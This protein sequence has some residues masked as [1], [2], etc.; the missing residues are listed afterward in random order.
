M[1]GHCRFRWQQEDVF[2]YEEGQLSAYLGC[3]YCFYENEGV[4]GPIVVTTSLLPW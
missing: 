2:G 1:P 4:P 3:D